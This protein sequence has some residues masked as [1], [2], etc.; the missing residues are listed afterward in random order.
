[1]IPSEPPKVHKTHLLSRHAPFCE[2]CAARGRGELA[3]PCQI[4]D[5]TLDVDE[6]MRRATECTCPRFVGFLESAASAPAQYDAMTRRRNASPCPLH[7]PRA[8]ATNG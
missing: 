5:D 8:E 7:G 1:M 6:R 2:K 4:S 3:A